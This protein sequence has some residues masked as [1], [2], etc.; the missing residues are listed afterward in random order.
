MGKKPYALHHYYF[1]LAIRVT[2]TPIPINP[3]QIDSIH[4]RTIVIHI[5]RQ[6]HAIPGNHIRSPHSIDVIDINIITQSVPLNTEDPRLTH[7]PRTHSRTSRTVVVKERVQSDTITED[8]I[9]AHNSQT[10]PRRCARR[11]VPRAIDKRRKDR[12]IERR[13]RREG[14]GSIGVGL[15][16]CGLGLDLAHKHIAGVNELVLVEDVVLDGGAPAVSN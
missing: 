3:K 14:N 6:I 1:L 4:K 9:T 2:R 13:V 8:I 12:I 7:R 15:V 5:A 10:P 16:V 11:A